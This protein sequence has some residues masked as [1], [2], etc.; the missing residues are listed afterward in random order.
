MIGSIFKWGVAMFS[1]RTAKYREKSPWSPF[2]ETTSSK[3]ETRT[4]CNGDQASSL[5]TPRIVPLP[6]AARNEDIELGLVVKKGTTVDK[7]QAPTH[8]ISCHLKQQHFTFGG[9]LSVIHLQWSV[10]AEHS[11]VPLWPHSRR[12]CH[13]LHAKGVL[14]LTRH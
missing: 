7:H 1:R 8:Q 13:Q 12:R 9:P 4:R 3:D 11:T 10:K 6:V 2:Y 5:R 14:Q